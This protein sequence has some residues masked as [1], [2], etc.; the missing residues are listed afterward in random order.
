MEI[1][2]RTITSEGLGGRN[3]FHPKVG[4]HPSG[5]LYMSLQTIGSGDYY[6][7]VEYC[8]SDDNGYTWSVP[9]AVPT[10]GWLELKGYEMSNEGV[11][12]TVVNYDYATG[13][14]VF[15]GHNAYYTH[16]RHMD[17]LGHWSKED[18]APELK[19]RGVY[20]ALRKDGTWAPRQ[21]FEP[22]EFARNISFVC[23][24][25]QR[26]VRPNGDW[27][28]AF[29]GEEF[30]HHPFCFVTVYRA[31]FNGDSFE[32]FERGNILTHRV[33]RGLLEP[34]LLE[35]KGEVLMTLRAEDGKAYCSRSRDG[36]NYEP[37]KTWKYDDGKELE[38]SSTQQHFLCTDDRL[39]LSYTRRNEVNEKVVRFRAPLYIAEVEP[40]IMTLI[41]DSEQ[42]IFPLDGDP[43]DGNTVHLSG[44]FMPTRL[45]KN[46]WIVT[47]GQC[48]P[49]QPMTS[50]FKIEH[51]TL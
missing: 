25:G 4:L 36:L 49:V 19:R 17:T 22:E 18:Y 50:P 41:R 5:R 23:G 9:K 2:V 39:Y 47:D 44:N 42:I 10:L 20:S 12:D 11:C 14:I 35:F 13:A 37:I 27:L 30:D 46:H 51:I 6:G 3:I 8:V 48:L 24:N 21:I 26:I 32:L 15:V 16:G 29:Y 43:A 1:D 38:T 33:G 34:S 31:R 45:D 40:T 28:I 7:P